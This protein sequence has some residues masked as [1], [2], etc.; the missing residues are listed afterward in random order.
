[1][2]ITA[3]ALLALNDHVFKARWPGVVTGKLSDVAGMVCFPLL[4]VA[5]SELVFARRPW[6]PSPVAVKLAVLATGLGFALV[7][8]WGPATD[9]WAWSWGLLQWPLRARDAVARGRAVDPLQPVAVVQDPTDLLALPALLLAWR[10][11]LARCEEAS[12]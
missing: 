8:T 6:R 2:V 11:G 9:A 4:L 5:L 3:F 7:K 12:K 10:V 1:M